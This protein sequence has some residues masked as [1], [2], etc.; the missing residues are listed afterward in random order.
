MGAPSVVRIHCRVVAVV[1]D[2]SGLVVGV[3]DGIAFAEQRVNSEATPMGQ[4]HRSKILQSVSEVAGNA[5][6]PLS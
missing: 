4:R 5:V 6:S 2:G 1:T 3:R